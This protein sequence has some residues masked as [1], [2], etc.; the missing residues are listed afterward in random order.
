[1][2]VSRSGEDIVSEKEE[3]AL[4]PAKKFAWSDVV[5]YSYSTIACILFGSKLVC[6]E[7]AH[8]TK[9]WIFFI[10]HLVI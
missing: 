8:F 9:I 5:F 1:M 6:L 4:I 10:E 2:K 7:L 3:A